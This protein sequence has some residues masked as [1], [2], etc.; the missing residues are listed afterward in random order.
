[1]LERA[2]TGLRE[3]LTPRRKFDWAVY[4][5]VATLI[6]TLTL[7]TLLGSGWAL[8]GLCLIAGGV[9]A[10][11][12]VFGAVKA[13]RRKWIVLLTVAVLWIGWPAVAILSVFVPFLRWASPFFETESLL[14]SFVQ[15]ALVTSLTMAFIGW[16]RPEG[17]RRTRG[18]L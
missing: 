10:G 1:M 16:L 8:R 3:D 5:V 7:L 15:G 11:I 12:V 13:A 4:G 18:T 2:I 9:S 17:E 6:A 14:Y